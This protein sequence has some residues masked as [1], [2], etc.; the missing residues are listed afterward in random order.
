MKNNI[1]SF[2]D[3][4]IGEESFSFLGGLDGFEDAVAQMEKRLGGVKLSDLEDGDPVAEEK[5]SRA[6]R[7]EGMKLLTQDLNRQS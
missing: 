7:K 1:I 2:P 6:L 3:K 4:K 5:A